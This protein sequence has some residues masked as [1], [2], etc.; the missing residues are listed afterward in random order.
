MKKIIITHKISGPFDS[1]LKNSGNEVIQLDKAK[2]SEAELCK[3]IKKHNPDAMVTFLTDSI[4]KKVLA[5]SPNLKIVSNY[6]VGFNN[7]D[8]EAAK[9]L[10]IA[11]ANTPISGYPVAEF[12]AS[13]AVSLM[14]RITEAHMFTAKGKY[15]GWDPNIFIGESLKGKTL[16]IIGSGQIGSNAAAIL[17]RGFGMN[18]LYSDIVKNEKI[19]AELGAKKVETDELFK[20]ADII[21]LHVA[22]NDSTRHLVSEARLGT[23]KKS[24][25]IIN[26]SRG[27]VVDERAL[28]NALSQKK[29]AG[30][31]IDVY[32]FEP[33]ITSSL[34]KM[35][36]VIL[37]PHIASATREAREEMAILAAQN[38]LD[39]I[40]GQKPKGA[41]FIP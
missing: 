19:E 26:T 11:V 25:V 18:I 37:T 3:I 7:I 27:P 30:A 29:I 2:Y 40:N 20:I 16:G 33:K 15:K 9:E 12:T 5:S 32:E 31:A 41:V 39:F 28:A 35:S 1:L 24:A 10:K 14:R 36:N 4:T 23:M 34:M 38:V 8:L 17:S 21:S 22:L 13:L 6:A